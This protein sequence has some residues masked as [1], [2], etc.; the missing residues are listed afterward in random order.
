M[1]IFLIGREGKE[2]FKKYW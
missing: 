2:N 1:V